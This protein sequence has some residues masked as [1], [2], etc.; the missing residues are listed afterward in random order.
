MNST[1]SNI[2][3]DSNHPRFKHARPTMWMYGAV[4][5]TCGYLVFSLLLAGTKGLS[6]GGFILAAIS[7]LW[8]VLGL[9]IKQAKFPL[10]LLIPTAFFITMV[11]SG[12]QLVI[13]P[14]E[15]IFRMIT[16]WV[17]AISVA[18][19]IANGI[20]P[21]LLV[22]WLMLIV[23]ANIV[24]IALGYDSRLVNTQGLNVDDLN[25]TEIQRFSGLAGHQNILI[26]IT[27]ALPF[28]LFFLR[29]KIPHILFFAVCAACIA[30][31]VLTGSRTGILFTAIYLVFG[32]LFLLPNSL[33]KLG[34]LIGGI[35]VTIAASIF[36]SDE[37]SISTIENSSLGEV[38]VVKRIINK[39]DDEDGSWETRDAMKNS[40][41]ELYGQKPITGHG[42]GMFKELA[43]F[44]TYAHNNFVE[45]GVNFGLVGLGAYYAMYAAILIGIIIAPHRNYFLLAP[46]LFL[47]LADNWFVTYVSRALVLCLCVLL[48]ISFPAFKMRSSNRKRRRRRSAPTF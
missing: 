13:Y 38:V 5:L 3:F 2:L 40:M 16:V 24:S 42:P 47:F 15:Y 46:L 28:S 23:I 39:I 9:I 35:T 44:D 18:T 11:L 48:A 33:L 30:I 19:F 20:S 12:L 6:S 7:G 43:G 1:L 17:G 10:I 31:T 14:T 8:L 41:T 26:A 22:S 25:R 32:S 21:K 29:S 45:L 36:I 4:A 37:N 34:V 27:F